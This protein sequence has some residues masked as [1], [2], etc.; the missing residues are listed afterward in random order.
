MKLVILQE[1]SDWKD[2]KIS[3]I[4][5]AFADYYRI[6]VLNVKEILQNVKEFADD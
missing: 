2:S 3:F 5:K 6:P 1:D 4:H